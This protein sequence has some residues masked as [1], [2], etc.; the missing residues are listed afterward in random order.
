M[1]Q[2]AAATALGVSTGTIALWERETRADTGKPVKI[3]K[4]VALACAALSF[5]IPEMP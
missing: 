1:S 2:R 3:P 4:T 5:G